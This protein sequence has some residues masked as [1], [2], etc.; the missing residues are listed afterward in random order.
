MSVFDWV[1]KIF[2]KNAPIPPKD[3]LDENPYQVPRDPEDMEEENIKLNAEEREELKA[4]IRKLYN[5]HEEI[6]TFISTLT[7]EHQ[8]NVLIYLGN[9]RRKKFRDEIENNLE[10]YKNKLIAEENNYMG[11]NHDQIQN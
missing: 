6:L 11:G 2:A 4:E 7:E 8:N 10:E 9:L 3:Y 5:K 1:L